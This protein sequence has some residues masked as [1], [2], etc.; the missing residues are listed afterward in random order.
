MKKEDTLGTISDEVYHT[1]K[2]WNEIYQNNRPL[3]KDP[4]LIF[5]GFTLYYIPDPIVSSA[6]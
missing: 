4:N 5:A 3:I 6:D 2:R 1:P